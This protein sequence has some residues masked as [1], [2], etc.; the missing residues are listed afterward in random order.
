MNLILLNEV[1][2]HK[3][4][5]DADRILYTLHNTHN[6]K[7]ITT[8]F[9]NNEIPGINVLDTPE[10]LLELI[11][12]KSPVTSIELLK[13]AFHEGAKASYLYFHLEKENF[14]A[15]KYHKFIHRSLEKYL[16]G[17]QSNE[18]ENNL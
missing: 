9:F 2:G 3:S 8:I 13:K 6:E 10:E 14:N 17:I 5:I 16:F 15:Y 7:D 12:K 18:T 1:T 11:D 4:L